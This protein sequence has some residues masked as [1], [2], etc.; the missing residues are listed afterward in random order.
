[1]SIHTLLTPFKSAFCIHYFV[2]KQEKKVGQTMWWIVPPHESQCKEKMDETTNFYNI[3]SLKKD[4]KQVQK[5]EEPTYE[6]TYGKTI[7]VLKLTAKN[8]LQQRNQV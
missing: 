8:S 2:D 6:I 3:I 1:M 5:L 4:G 7:T